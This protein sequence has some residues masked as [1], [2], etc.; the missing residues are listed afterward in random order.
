LRKS[1]KQYIIISFIISYLCFGIIVYSKTSFYNLF[2]NSLYLS[3]FVIGFLGPLISSFFVHS[4]NKDE[5]GGIN[6]F[7]IRFRTLKLKKDFILVP[8]FLIAHYIFAISL[9]NVHKIDDF[10]SL[11]YYIP[12]MMVLLGTQEIGWRGIVQPDLEEKR[13]FWKAAISTGLFWA[14]W[15][16]PLIFIPQFIILPQY[17]TQFAIY[18]VGIGFL[19]STV[20]KTSGSITYSVILSGLIFSISQVVILKQSSMLVGIAVLEAIVASIFKDKKFI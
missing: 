4:I 14:L 15:F 19:L 3:L 18:L 17:Y 13:G 8:L 7:I 6:G 11:I 2:S 1:S 20:Y 10:S 12:I 5:L 16:L 9:K